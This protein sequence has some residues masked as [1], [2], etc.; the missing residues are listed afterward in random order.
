MSA[1][2]VV[3]GGGLSC[4]LVH[5]S[6]R[7]GVGLGGLALVGGSL[8][9]HGGQVAGA[10]GSLDLSFGSQSPHYDCRCRRIDWFLRVGLCFVLRLLSF[11]RGFVAAGL[12]ALT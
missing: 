7:L 11:P 10:V 5:P 6:T 2:V 4:V 12:V 8:A 3:H 1:E 9:L